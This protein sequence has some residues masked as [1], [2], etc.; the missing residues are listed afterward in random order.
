[1]LQAMIHHEEHEE[2]NH[3]KKKTL[4]SS[5]SFV[6]FVVKKN[7]AFSALSAV[8]S[9]VAATRP[10]RHYRYRIEHVNS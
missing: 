5:C 8:N 9:G 6:S 7:S 3:E 4:S 10:L 2:E 1:M